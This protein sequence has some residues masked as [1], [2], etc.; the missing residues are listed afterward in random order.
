MWWREPRRWRRTARLTR[1][2]MVLAAAALTAGCFEPLYGARPAAN[3]ESVQDKFAA[4]EIPPIV[5]PNGSPAARIAVGMH[6]ALQFDLHNGGNA[7]APTYQLKVTVTT[8]QFT[9]V[10]DPTTG[11]PNTQIDNVGARYQ[12]IEM[13]TG[14]TVVTD[15]CFAHVDYDIPGSEQRFAKQRAQRNAEDRAV[16]VVAESIRNRLASFFVAGT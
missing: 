4:I 12:L 2:A 1:L 16:E 15:N 14:K 11:R 3:S 8:S 13:A 5:A 9:A 7:F 6:N 10:I